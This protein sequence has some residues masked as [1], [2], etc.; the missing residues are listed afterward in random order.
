VSLKHGVYAALPIVIGEDNIA[1]ATLRNAR[2]LR[3]EPACHR[4]EDAVSNRVR[5]TWLLDRLS[6]AEA[7]IWNSA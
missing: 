6:K 7:H 1:L 3:F 2:F 5:N 4:R